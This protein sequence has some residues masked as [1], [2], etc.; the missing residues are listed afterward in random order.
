MDSSVRRDVAA[1]GECMDEGAL[2]HPQVPGQLEQRPQVIDMGVDAAVRDE[3]EQVNVRPTQLGS[4]ERAHEGGVLEERS[5]GDRAVHAL[6]V[7]V[8]DAP[9]ADRQ[10]PDFRVPHLPGR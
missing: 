2:L 5:V 7:L 4:L 1:V 9:G 8:E 10:M 3:T 6:E